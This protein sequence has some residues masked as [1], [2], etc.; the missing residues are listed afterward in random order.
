[1]GFYF[2]KSVGAGPFRM[3]FSKSGISYSV[4]PKGAKINFGP[5]GTYVNFGSHGIYYREK[6]S[7]FGKKSHSTNPYT[8]PPQVS[9]L[10]QHTITSS[11]I[12]E[13]TDRDS[14]DFINEMNSKAKKTPYFVWFGV[15]PVVIVL[16]ALIVLDDAFKNSQIIFW[17]ILGIF[18]I[19]STILLRHLFYLD[20]QR[21]SIEICYELDDNIKRVYDQFIIKFSEILK[22]SAVWQYL[23]SER[24][25]DYKYTGGAS[26]LINRKPLN[27]ISINKSPIRHFKTNV[28]IPYLGLI[29]TEMFFFPE[30]L[31][32]KRGTTYGAIM[33]KHV[34][35]IIENKRFIESDTVL[36]DALI[37][38]YTWQYLNKNGSPDRRFNNNRKLPI[39]Q[40]SE[41]F[42]KSD[43]GL[44]EKISTSK[45]GGIDDFIKYIKTIGSL[46]QHLP[47]DI[48]NN[49]TPNSK[50]IN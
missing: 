15:C 37:V 23:H 30:R 6:I 40:Y 4:G 24:T 22:C 47:S 13:I 18:S 17:G 5:R 3:N 46:Q 14:H 38:D 1:M 27:K 8:T 10:E 7:N 26:N 33:Y 49:N 41:Y 39:C 48:S 36:S 44:N 29:N 50:F 21:L 12:E 35:C 9:N 32:I 28:N 42:F 2:R 20:K 45:L 16:F 25:Y 31:I 34:N 19:I 11:N 43:S